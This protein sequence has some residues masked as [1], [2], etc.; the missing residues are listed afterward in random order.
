M[1]TDEYSEIT[2]YQRRDL[3]TE[4]AQEPVPGYKNLKGDL[5]ISGGS[6]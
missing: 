2:P 6:V 5:Q 1:E 3:C 4:T